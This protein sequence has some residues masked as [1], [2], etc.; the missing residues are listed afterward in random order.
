MPVR[1]DSLDDPAGVTVVTLDRQDRRNA[2]DH[3]HLTELRAAVRSAT[4]DGVRALVLTGAGRNFCAGAD[5]STVEDEG[6]VAT[7]R[8]TLEDL[9]TAP[10][11]VIGAI[12]G[13]ALGAGTQLAMA[14]DL[15]LA[16]CGA[17][18]GIPAAKL[19][20][21]VDAY[22]VH[23]LSGAVGHSV[24]RAM[25]VGTET[26]GGTALADSGFIHRLVDDDTDMRAAGVEWAGE[27]VRLAPLT[28]AAHKAML[29]DAEVPVEPSTAAI[30][31]RLAA[32]RSDDLA[33]G[34]A[35]FAGKRRPEFHGR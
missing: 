5:L 29:A 17:T 3:A 16:T 8:G 6:F 9:R 24:A 18:F 15:R 4:D 10:F 25:L 12:H 26:F 23:H 11:A 32:W 28:I 20:L 13:P 19:G 33:A 2:L 22:T 31:A 27:V 1:I 35:A 7:L 21:T 34:L 14:C 30:E